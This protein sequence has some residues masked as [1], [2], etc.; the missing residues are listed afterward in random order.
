MW[1]EPGRAPRCSRVEH[2]LSSGRGPR[3]SR[4][5]LKKD[6]QA[7]SELRRD[8]KVRSVCTDSGSRSSLFFSVFSSSKGLR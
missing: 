1:G 4:R 7:T 3:K 2:I 5:E 6:P 8:G